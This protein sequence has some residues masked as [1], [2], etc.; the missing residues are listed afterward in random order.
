MILRGSRRRT[1]VEWLPWIAIFSIVRDQDS[2]FGFIHANARLCAQ[3]P[4]ERCRVGRRV[5]TADGECRELRVFHDERAATEAVEILDHL[6]ER[7][8]LKDEPSI[9]PGGS[10]L[11][12]DRLGR[13]KIARAY[14]EALAGRKLDG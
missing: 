1:Q 7:R 11:D 8:R 10:A 12:I 13:R 14:H 6:T 5:H 9:R 4:N 2:R 3:E